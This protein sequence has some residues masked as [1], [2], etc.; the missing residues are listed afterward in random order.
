MVV[1]SVKKSECKRYS[2]LPLDSSRWILNVNIFAVPVY[3][4]CIY[5]KSKP[6]WFSSSLENS[7]IALQRLLVVLPPDKED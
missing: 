5:W 3:F 1:E 6:R 4:V 7:T 2:A